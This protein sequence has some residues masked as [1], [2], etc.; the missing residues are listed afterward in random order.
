MFWDGINTR[1]L[2][3]SVVGCHIFV[4]IKL[5]NIQF[6]E[7]IF[8]MIPHKKF[9]M[10][11]MCTSSSPQQLQYT[12]YTADVHTFVEAQIL[13]DTEDGLIA[14]WVIGIGRFSA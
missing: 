5:E 9:D 11:F 4:A 13:L 8:H 3:G 1:H 7:E 6:G 2:A 12:T 14:Q 10:I